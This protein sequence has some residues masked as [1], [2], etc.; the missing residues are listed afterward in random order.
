VVLAVD[1]TPKITDF[2]LAKRLETESGPT[3]SGNLLGTPPYMAPEQADGRAEI[4][5]RADVYG[6]GAVLYEMLTGRPPFQG[7]NELDTLLQVRRCWV[8][9]PRR[10]NRS[11]DRRLESICLKCLER[12]PRRRYPSARALADDLERWQCR[13]RPRA[14][15]LPARASRLVRRHPRLTVLLL[16]GLVALAIPIVNYLTSQERALRLAL[17]RLAEGEEVTWI[18]NTGRPLFCRPVLPYRDEII[19]RSE[20][21][22]FVFGSKTIG[23]LE[24]VPDPQYPHY[25]FSAEVRREDVQPG[26]D[27]GIYLLYSQHGTA[28]A[29]TKS[30]WYCAASFDDSPTRLNSSLSL[31][32]EHHFQPSNTRFG[33]VPYASL[34][35]AKSAEKVWHKIVVE[36]SPTKVRLEWDG[37]SIAP[38]RR[39]LNKIVDR[40]FNEE[41]RIRIE[42]HKPPLT[43]RSPLGLYA[44]MGSASFRNVVLKPIPRAAGE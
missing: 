24:L 16:V 11:V 25:V 31:R 44:R 35:Y 10:H 15:W 12:R 19:S 29:S 28:D 7:E 38:S 34:R 5:G 26:G 20:D 32:V 6:L 41:L 4:D 17:E 2:G 27:V 8:V 1:G 14:H 18:G 40:M 33:S 13:R 37:R 36:V 39:E 3:R 42:E 9:L 22:A 21:G 30:H 43:P 23:F